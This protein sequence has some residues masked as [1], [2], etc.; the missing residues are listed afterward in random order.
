MPIQEFIMRIS[1]DHAKYVAAK[2]TKTSI[3]KVYQLDRINKRLD[4]FQYSNMIEA[5]EKE[6][7]VQFTDREYDFIWKKNFESLYN[8]VDLK[9][10]IQ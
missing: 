5:F 1:L 4:E 8:L 9:K 6:F 7:G 3:I 2:S 10:N